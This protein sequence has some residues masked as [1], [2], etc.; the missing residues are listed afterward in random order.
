M[1]QTFL[2][3]IGVVGMILLFFVVVQVISNALDRKD[4]LKHRIQSAVTRKAAF[5]EGTQSSAFRRSKESMLEKKLNQ[6]FSRT[7]R[8]DSFIKLKLHRCGVTLDVRVLFWIG[9]MLWFIAFAL[10]GL[11]TNFGILNN[12]VG[13]LLIAFAVFFGSLGF[14]EAQRKNQITQH[15]TPAL[16]IILRG[17]R[18]GSSIER[19]FEVVSREVPSPLKEEFQK[20]TQ[21]LEFGISYEEVMHQAAQRIDVSDFYFLSTALVIQRKSGGSLADVLENI[22][23]SLNKTQELRMKIQIFSSEAKVSSF[24]L[25]GMPVVVWIVMM[26]AN[27]QYL[28]FFRYD[29]S[30]QRMLMIA[31]GLVVGAGFIIRRMIRIE[32]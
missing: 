12:L 18:A 31:V 27:P 11:F 4:K 29:A 17:L 7:P 19:T 15:L 22:I 25:G 1:D 6:Y 5:A 13:S 24:I 10:L 16:D 20:I 23:Q 28:D 8:G 3:G 30:G 21:Q 14:L 26:N 9:L 32:I 2:L